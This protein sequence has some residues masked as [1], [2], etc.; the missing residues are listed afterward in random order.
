MN[1]I[2]LFLM[3]TLL[4]LSFVL[5]G[6]QGN[7][8]DTPASNSL[9]NGGSVDGTLPP[10]PDLNATDA[11][12]VIL[13]ISSA[14]LTK[15][16][17]S[18]NITVKAIDSKN[19]PY[20]SGNI[21]I[22]FPNDVRNGRDV[23][24]F[25]DITLPLDNNTTKQGEVTFVYHAPAD[26]SINT[27]NIV[28]GFFHDSNP[29]NVLTFIMTIE[30]I[31]NQPVNNKYTID[32]GIGTNV[33]M[34]P[35]DEK[36]V[37][38]VVVDE[39][40][41]AV[42][43]DKI[44]SISVITLNPNIATLH[45]G[46]T[47]GNTVSFSTNNVSLSVISKTRSG[48]VPLLVS[49]SFK[50]RN[51]ID[52]DIT[53]QFNILVLSGPPSALS[54][55]YESTKD[56]ADIPAGFT[57][58]WII[59]VTD[60]YNNVVNT[61]PSVSMGLISGYALD[62]ASSGVGGAAN[63]YL[64]FTTGGTLSKTSNHFTA[65]TGVFSSV[66]AAT[67]TLVTFGAGYTY[68]ASG[69]WDFTKN[70]ATTLDLIDTY[71]GNNTTNL[72]FAVGHNYRQDPRGGEAIATV[73][74]KDDNFLLN[75]SG[76]MTLEI[77]Y[78]YYL[79]GKD[80]VLWVNLIGK[81]LKNGITTKIGE[82]K[83]ITLRA[84]GLEDDTIKTT[85]NSLNEDYTFQLKIKNSPSLYRDANFGVKYELSDKLELNSV[86]TSNGTLNGTAFI[87]FN[88]TDISA[89]GESGTITITDGLVSTEF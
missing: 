1:K 30:P 33:T 75:A 41:V 31:A 84:H 59:K 52:Q 14:K 89:T 85:A 19:R 5:S 88:V 80:V 40:G 56:K 21:E 67:D 61:N 6:C 3:G 12:S 60:K 65:A 35:E 79:T 7:N 48:I 45:E 77:S 29:A 78:D 55:S 13:P 69:K 8:S 43:D 64:Y 81:D 36:S 73:K 32:T 53:K 18:F 82:A 27:S 42:A 83:K 24:Y 57:E 25:D 37:N 51:D 49:A 20:S 87:T 34:L 86:T 38:Y 28:F 47:N 16:S 46:L 50:D 66:D 9:I 23:G 11:I 26:L 70:N 74:P 58:N 63:N 71:D 68:P 76:Y 44:T 22:I 17:D 62:S 72:G 39:N 15:N 10:P 54:I 4:T 2:N